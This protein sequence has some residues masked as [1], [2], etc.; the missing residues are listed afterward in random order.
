MLKVIARTRANVAQNTDQQNSS[1]KVDKWA[2]FEDSRLPIPFPVL[3]SFWQ[4]QQ[5]AYIFNHQQVVCFKYN[6][7]LIFFN[8]Y[9]QIAL[10]YYNC[11]LQITR[12]MRWFL[13]SYSIFQ[14]AVKFN[15]PLDSFVWKLTYKKPLAYYYYL[16]FFNHISLLKKKKEKKKQNWVRAVSQLYAEQIG[17]HRCTFFFQNRLICRI[18]VRSTRKTVFDGKLVF[19]RKTCLM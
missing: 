6:A 2:A 15:N 14:L 9:L 16:L 12:A 13:Q 4:L 11:S 8:E 18:H 17:K 10:K 7:M 19:R 3:F 5:F 1:S